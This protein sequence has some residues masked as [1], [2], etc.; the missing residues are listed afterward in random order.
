MASDLPAGRMVGWVYLLLGG[1]GAHGAPRAQ[2]QGPPRLH[3][4]TS[5]KT[6]QYS[7]RG[8]AGGP[9]LGSAGYAG[10]GTVGVTI[11]SDYGDMGDYGRHVGGFVSSSS[12]HGRV[13]RRGKSDRR[14]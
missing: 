12:A 10:G 4:P 11:S 9:F 13:P 2:E 14:Q 6:A 1:R 8:H 3:Y 5:N 7:G